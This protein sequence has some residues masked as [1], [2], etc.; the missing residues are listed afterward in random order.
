MREDQSHLIKDHGYDPIER[1]EYPQLPASEFLGTEIHVIFVLGGPGAG[2]GT[3]CAKLARDFHMYHLSVGD[4]LRE[5]RD[6]RQRIWRAHCS[7]YGGGPHWPY[8]N[9][10]NVVREGFESGLLQA[11][12]ESLLN[13]R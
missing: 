1:I 5:E 3:Q 11:Q 9:Y 2:K 13:R 10:G 6:T 7:Q 12:C 8:G 4:A